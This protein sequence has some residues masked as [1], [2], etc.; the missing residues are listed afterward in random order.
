MPRKSNEEHAQK[1]QKENRKTPDKTT[2]KGREI[3]VSNRTFFDIVTSLNGA[4]SPHCH[5]Q[6]REAKGANKWEFRFLFASDDQLRP[7]SLSDPATA[8]SSPSV[9]HTARGDPP[10]VNGAVLVKAKCLFVKI[11]AH[12]LGLA[13]KTD[14]RSDLK[15]GLGQELKS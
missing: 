10:V 13:M 4:E 1:R 2:E 8:V 15:F 5:C 9:A 3:R 14:Y 6:G 11:G 12:V 7:P